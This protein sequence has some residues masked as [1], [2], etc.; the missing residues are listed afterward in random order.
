MLVP[1]PSRTPQSGGFCP[2]LPLGWGV[3]RPQSRRGLEPWR[4]RVESRGARGRDRV[5]MLAM[6]CH[7]RLDEDQKE[8]KCHP[9]MLLKSQESP[10]E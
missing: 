10:E 3:W 2:D 1:S 6:D 4:G 8:N 7:Q 9:L 5:R